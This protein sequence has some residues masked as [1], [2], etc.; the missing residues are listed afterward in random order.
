MTEERDYKEIYDKLN[1][2][3]FGGELPGAITGDY[4]QLISEYPG[5]PAVK[6]VDVDATAYITYASDEAGKEHYFIVFDEFEEET[7]LHEMIHQYNHLHSI[8]DYDPNAPAGKDKHLPAFYETARFHGLTGEEFDGFRAD[9]FAKC[10]IQVEP[11]TT[12]VTTYPETID[13]KTIYFIGPK[14]NQTKLEGNKCE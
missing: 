5:L 6:A 4:N 12:E 10:G 9:D 2:V 13:G 14:R 1:A 8:K 7:L 11:I 3:F